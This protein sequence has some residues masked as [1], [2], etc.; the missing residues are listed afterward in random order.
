MKRPLNY[1][2]L[3]GGADAFIGAVH[4]SAARLDGRWNLVAGLV[5]K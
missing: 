1:A 2:M 5:D 4:R 3:G